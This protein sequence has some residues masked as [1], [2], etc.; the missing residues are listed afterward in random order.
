MGE[1]PEA[2]GECC[3][4]CGGGGA[5][6]L[7]RNFPFTRDQ[8]LDEMDHLALADGENTVIYKM[9]NALQMRLGDEGE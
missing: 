1:D 3:T 7:V 8:V 4:A 6:W 9:M 5:L 2:E